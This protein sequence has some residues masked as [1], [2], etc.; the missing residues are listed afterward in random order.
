MMH[1]MFY[2]RVLNIFRQNTVVN[3]GE[4]RDLIPTETSLAYHFY[5]NHNY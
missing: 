1:I 5:R 2:R 3:I 4:T